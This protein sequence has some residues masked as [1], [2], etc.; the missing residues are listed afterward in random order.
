MMAGEQ[1]M[2]GGK[3]RRMTEALAAAHARAVASGHSIVIARGGVVLRIFSDGSE[4]VLKHI[5][6]PMEVE[7]GTTIRFNSSMIL[8]SPFGFAFGLRRGT[9]DTAMKKAE[10]TLKDTIGKL[11]STVSELKEAVAK[12]AAECLKRD[13]ADCECSDEKAPQVN[14]D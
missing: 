11:S 4:E 12:H 13:A 14:T 5:E 1:W 10:K 8:C 6:K 3:M 9:E 7:L 2:E